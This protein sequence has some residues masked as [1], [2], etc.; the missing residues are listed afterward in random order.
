MKK[1]LIGLFL[2]ASLSVLGANSQKKTTSTSNY[3]ANIDNQYFAVDGSLMNMYSKEKTEFKNKYMAL[4]QKR[5]KKNLIALLKEYVKKYPNDAYAYEEI[6]TDY[7]ILGNQ[8]EAEK[9]Y[10]KAIE[11]GDDDTGVYSLFLLYSDEDYLKSLNLTVKEKNEKNSI[12][13]KYEKQLSDAGFT[14]DKL[15]ELR[16]HKQMALIGNAYSI[17]R[18]AIYYSG[19]KNHKMAEK[20]A[21]EFLEFDKTNPEILNILKN[22][23]K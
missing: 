9:Y 17:Y 16:E 15:K 12:V 1:V 10:L 22:I 14:H 3:T 8:K 20:Y 7:D 21:K 5:D 19:T 18:L 23:S 11:L 6:G 2:I 13:D 4:T